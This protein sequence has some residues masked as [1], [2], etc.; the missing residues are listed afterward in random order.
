MS[1]TTNRDEL[2]EKFAD[3]ST[4]K[5]DIDRRGHV[6]SDLLASRLSA[7]EYVD[8]KRLMVEKTR[9]RLQR[10][11]LDDW[12]RLAE[13]QLTEL[14]TSTDDYVQDLASHC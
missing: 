8:Y 9:L 11:E 7:D 6:I 4:L 2:T 5:S 12:L 1:L 3:A 13:Q 14:S 10:Q